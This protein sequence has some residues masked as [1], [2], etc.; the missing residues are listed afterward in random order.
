MSPQLLELG[1]KLVKYCNEKEFEKALEELYADNAVHVE[2]YQFMPD[3]PRE[4][5]GLI[6]IKEGS[7]EW[8]DNHEIHGT[9]V[10]GPYP[11]GDDRFA[12]WMMIDVT[13]KAGPFAGKRMKMEEVCHYTVNN[14]KIVRAE[15]M[16]D[17]SA[18]G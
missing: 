1:R 4:T 6:K 5:V 16:W 18:M 17:P 8:S 13:A 3:K 15:F 2:A 9:E 14:G 11:F 7:K 12:V 10:K